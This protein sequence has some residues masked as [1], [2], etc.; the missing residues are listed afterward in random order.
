MIKPELYFFAGNA[1]TIVLTVINRGNSFNKIKCSIVQWLY[2]RYDALSALHFKQHKYYES[3]NCKPQSPFKKRIGKKKTK[4]S[5]CT[6]TTGFI[7]F[8]PMHSCN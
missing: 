5:I 6:F 8:I 7:I 4:R 1:V 2:Y 3:N